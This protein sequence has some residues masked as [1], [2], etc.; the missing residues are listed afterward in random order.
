VRPRVS[1]MNNIFGDDWEIVSRRTNN[2]FVNLFFIVVQMFLTAEPANR[3]TVTFTVRQRSTGL[4]RNVT[5]R[6]EQEAAEMIA[7][8]WFDLDRPAS[9]K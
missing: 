8:G 6:S 9:N 7:N 1:K 2:A 4:T 3:S 5:A